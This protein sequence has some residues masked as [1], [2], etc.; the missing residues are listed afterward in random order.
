M[1]R[2]GLLFE[3]ISYNK[4]FPLGFFSLS[5][6][7]PTYFFDK[8]SK[9]TNILFSMLFKYYYF[10]LKNM[11]INQLFLLNKFPFSILH[12][13]SVYCYHYKEYYNLFLPLAVM[14][15]VFDFHTNILFYKS[16]SIQL[17]LIHYFE[18]I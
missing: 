17:K 12:H 8:K 15:M 10:E 5:S 3:P 7:H 11:N 14:I 13:T 4:Y 6:K 2:L 18:N 9:H 1:H 16:K